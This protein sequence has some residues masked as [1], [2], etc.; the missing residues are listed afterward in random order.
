MSSGPGLFLDIGKKA[1]DLLTRDYLSD[2][3][4]S[5]STYSESG[6]ALTTSTVRK[7]GYTS[8]DVVALYKYKNTATEL[9]VDTESNILATVTIANIIPSSK[10]VATIKH[11]LYQSSK[12]EF[13]YFHPHASLTA[14][15]GL[16]Q[17]PAIDFSVT[18]GTPTFALGA[19]AGYETTSSK[20]T[21]YTAGISV[22]KPDS[23]ASVILGDKG[24]TIKASYVHYLDQSK[25]SA[26]VGE[27]SR[28]FSTNENT[29][30]VGGSCAIDN[31]TQ[32]KL[33]L[34]NHGSLATV[35]QHEVIP[36]SLVTIS[37]EFDTK[38]LDKTPRFGVA[39]AL[40]P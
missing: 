38:A 36:K 26:A 7:G 21:K 27:I 19:E 8:G 10:T 18:L 20:L 1:K 13:Q 16:N 28:R 39:L 31:L 25:R 9:K 11:P 3:K 29:F 23:C 40:K 5:V 32:V 34:N 4:F 2:H 30:T 22:T 12:L 17:T 33:K 15:V 37:S 6:V 14:A 24:D 35:L